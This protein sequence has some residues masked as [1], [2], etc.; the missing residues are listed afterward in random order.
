MKEEAERRIKI[1]ND[2][3][4]ALSE[5]EKMVHGTVLK[6]PTGLAIRKETARKFWEVESE[7]VKD[8]VLASIET[9]KALALTAMA[10]KNEPPKTPGQYHL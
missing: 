3:F 6:R 5:E 9:K 2:A 10:A 4:D 1:A 7:Y 8:E